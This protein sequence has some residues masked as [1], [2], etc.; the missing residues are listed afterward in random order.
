MLFFVRDNKSDEI[1]GTNARYLDCFQTRLFF[2]LFQ[3]GPSLL[4]VSEV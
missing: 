3:G 1:D 2:L 4:A